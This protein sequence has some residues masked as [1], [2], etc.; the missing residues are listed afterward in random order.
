MLAPDAT[1]I[2]PLAPLLPLPTV[3]LTAPALPPVDAAVPIAKR[4]EEPVVDVPELN[5]RTPLIPASPALD[6]VIVIAP[7]VLA[8]LCP[9]N[10][11]TAPPVWTVLSPDATMMRPPMPLLPLPTVMD[12][13]PLLPPVAAPDPTAID[14]LV[15]ELAVP[16]L[17]ESNPLA[18][19]CPAFDDA[20]VTTPLVL[21]MLC[22][23]TMPTAP[24]VCTVLSPDAT[25]I[26]PPAPLL[27]LPTV[28]LTAPALPAVAAPLPME[29]EPLPPELDVPEV[30]DNR[31]DA[32]L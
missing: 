10:T 11:P 14:P 28:M 20:I 23:L 3:M 30:N 18:P 31:P 12:S 17:N 27:P 25:V 6:D 1:V 24:P 9:L 32:P 16:E 29:I 15:P 5:D 2:K 21:A 22:P 26:K 8:M 7:L 19:L 13:A 4:P